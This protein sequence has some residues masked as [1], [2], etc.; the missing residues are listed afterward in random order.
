MVHPD[1]LPQQSQLISIAE[2]SDFY[3]A[4]TFLVAEQGQ[5]PAQVYHAILGQLPMFVRQ[6]MS[7]RNKLVKPLGFEVQDIQ[8]IPSAEALQVGKGEGLHRVEYLDES[9]IVCSTSEKHMRVWLSVYK[10]SA[11]QFTISTMVETHSTIGKGYLMAI[12]PFHK[13]VAIASVRSMLK[14]V[15]KR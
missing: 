7:V 6:L 4:F 2:Q 9:E 8:T 13:L 11:F 3:D 1:K 10:R 14:R 15:E 5:T 12:I